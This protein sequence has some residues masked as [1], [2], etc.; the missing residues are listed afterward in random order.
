MG[1][2]WD[3]TFP[4]LGGFLVFQRQPLVLGFEILDIEEP[5]VLVFESVG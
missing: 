3:K 1:G 2:M 4:V 5:Q